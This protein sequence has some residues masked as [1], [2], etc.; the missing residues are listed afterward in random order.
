VPAAWTLALD[1]RHRLVLIDDDQ[2]EISNLHRQILYRS[3]DIGMPKAERLAAALREIEP[4]LE[5][6]VRRGRLSPLNAGELLQGCDAVIEGTDD[7][8]SKFAVNDLVI[9]GR[10]PK[11]ASIAAAIGRRGQWMVVRQAGPCYRCLF[12]EPPPAESLA[13]CQIA[14][15]LGPAVGQLGA[16]AARSLLAALDGRPD[17]ADGALV[18]LTARGILRTAVAAAGDCR[19]QGQFAEV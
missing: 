3:V 17:P 7:A 18:R 5:V 4:N 14:G 6:E 19:C 12:E 10:G 15:V 13:T 11:I 8:V 16:L 9:G 2:V 1:A